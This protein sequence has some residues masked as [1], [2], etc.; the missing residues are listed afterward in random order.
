MVSKPHYE[1]GSVIRH[2]LFGYRGVIYAI[3]P[4]FSLED[5]WYEQVAKSRPPKNA[6]WYGVMVHKHEQTT[7][8]AEQN[9]E[10]ELGPEQIEHPALGQVFDA[11]I[12][13]RYR[14]KK[15]L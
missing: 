6:P 9:L 4:V 8:V 13:G 1:V 12:N 5:T 10:L 2:K 14:A 7:Y 15:M 11:F 3:D